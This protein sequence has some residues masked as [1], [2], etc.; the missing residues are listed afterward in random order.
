MWQ[1]LAIKLSMLAV[2]IGV[3]YWIGWTV[4]STLTRPA[5]SEVESDLEPNP[6]TPP[7][8]NPPGSVSFAPT[9]AGS[10]HPQHP[11]G[12]VKLERAKL[13]LNRADVL[14]LEELPGIGPVLAERIVDY[15]KSGRTFRTVEDLRKVKGIGQKKF[16]RIRALVTVTRTN[17]QP[18]RGK[19]VA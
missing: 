5:H 3:V 8:A 17:S 9:L 6:G 1:S 13:D 12:G 14:E 7:V 16:E 18:T 2:T 15:R 10:S 19:K 11:G 4:P